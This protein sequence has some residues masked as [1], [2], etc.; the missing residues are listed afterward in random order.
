MD[1]RMTTARGTYNRLRCGVHS[2]FGLP[3]EANSL[4]NGLL[5]E[6]A[7]KLCHDERVSATRRNPQYDEPPVRSVVLT[8]YYAPINDFGL[9]LALELAKLWA[10]RYPAITQEPLRPRPPELPA[11]SP[12]EGITWPF[13]RVMQTDNTLSRSISYQFDQFSLRWTFDGG[14]QA[15]KYPGFNALFDELKEVYQKF[16]NAVDKMSESSVSIQACG[17][18]YANNF[19]DISPESWVVGFVS[20]WNESIPEASI[21]VDDKKVFLRF[22]GTSNNDNI[23]QS[24]SIQ[25]SRKKAKGSSI[26]IR[27]SARLST[28]ESVTQNREHLSVDALMESAHDLLIE[29]FEKASDDAMKERWGRHGSPNA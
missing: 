16:S 29:N 18:E 23:E 28:E 13:P 8:V 3:I 22:T 1:G 27:A 7:P 20:G 12:F 6:A 21:T 17:C 2:F 5:P 9:P 26:R 25:V 11:S 19:D 24:Y 10:E 4:D 14:V 15:N